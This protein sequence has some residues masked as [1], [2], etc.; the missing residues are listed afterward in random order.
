MCGHRKQGL[1]SLEQSDKL[2]CPVLL[3]LLISVTHGPYVTVATMG[4]TSTK[5]CEASFG[6]VLLGANMFVL[7]KLA[8]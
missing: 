6:T 4:G 1:F 3:M 2:T 5:F 7:N 8:Y